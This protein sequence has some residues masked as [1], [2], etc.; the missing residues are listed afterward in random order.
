M[1]SIYECL[2]LL[3]KANIFINCNLNYSDSYNNKEIRQLIKFQLTKSSPSHI[4]AYYHAVGYMTKKYTCMYEVDL[5]T[6]KW[7]TV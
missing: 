1:A 7:H 5:L 4:R 3:S 6:C 2:A